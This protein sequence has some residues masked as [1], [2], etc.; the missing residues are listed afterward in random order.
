MR[1]EVFI[2]INFF[3]VLNLTFGT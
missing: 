3:A 2:Y 1:T